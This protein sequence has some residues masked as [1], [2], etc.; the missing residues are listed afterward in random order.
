MVFGGKKKETPPAAAEP[1]RSSW[2][3]GLADALPKRASFFTALRTE[4]FANENAVQNYVE[5]WAALRVDEKSDQWRVMHYMLYDLDKA[6]GKFVS[7][8][9]F[10]RGMSFAEAVFHLGGFEY[11]GQ[12]LLNLKAVDMPAT[13]PREKFPELSAYFYDLPHYKGAA[14]IE[15]I[16]F[17]DY[18]EPYRRVQGVVVGSS[19]FKR[20]EVL[21][22]LEAPERAREHP[23]VLAQIE[24][25][26]L[27]DVF[28][29]VSGRKVGLDDLLKVGEIIAAMD[30]FAS[31]VGTMY[32][33]VQK[34][35]G[36]EDRFDK[37]G[38]MAPDEKT[39][40]LKRAQ[41]A[42]IPPLVTDVSGIPLY[43]VGEMKKTLGKAEELGVHVEPFQKFAA[44]CELYIQLLNASQKLAALE[45]SFVR[46]SGTDTTQIAEIRQSVAKAQETFI[47]LGGT[48]EQTD[49]LKAWVADRK[50]DP[51]PSWLPGFLTRYYESRT[52][53][54][55][56]VQERQSGLTQVKTMTAEVKPPVADKNNPGAPAPG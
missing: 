50:K 15:G 20:S 49:K 31:Q 45:R 25:G 11:Q 9:V 21:A 48:Q 42:V 10:K 30:E 53:V 44:E 17:D 34:M 55:Q 6:D 19:T 2:N 13:Y 35:T 29:S 4:A 47:S 18:N 41:E 5:F 28:A 26:V 38:G 16:A 54:M 27:K 24:G 8:D 39:A 1:K 40:A 33:S 36:T 7:E 37:V 56:R 43:M 12:D 23:A 14:N 22:P 3:D 46:A 52:R 32:L 51:I